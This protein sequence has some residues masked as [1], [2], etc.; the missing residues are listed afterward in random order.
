VLRRP[1]GE[2]MALLAT[3]SEVGVAVG[4][5]RLLAEIGIACRVVSMPCVDVFDRQDASYRADVIPRHLP[6]LAVEA[7][8]TGL[9]WKYVGEQG[10]VIGLD[11]FGE[12]APAGAL[13]KHFGFTAEAVAARARQMVKPRH[14]V[15]DRDSSL[16]SHVILS[17]H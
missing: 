6:R 4:A 14:V 7:G 16:E 15:A 1:E 10:D 5:A 13:F 11:R 12:S 2:C 9:W 8:S 3:G 17:S